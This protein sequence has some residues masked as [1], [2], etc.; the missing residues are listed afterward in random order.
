MQVRRMIPGVVLPA[1]FLC[2]ATWAQAPNM[3]KGELVLFNGK[4][5]TGAG[6]PGDPEPTAIA[7]VGDSIQAIGTDDQILLR[8]G[9]TTQSIDVGGRRIIPGITDSH[10]HL[11]SGGFFLSR[12]QLRDV[13]SKEEFIAAVAEAAK[14]IKPGEWILGGRWTVESWAKPESPHRS[15]IDAAT[16]GAPTM[17]NRMDGHSAL[18]NS[19]ALKLAGIDANG[20]PDP[21]G[22]EIERDPTTKQPTG[23]LKDAAMELVSKHIPQPTLENR[24]EALANAMKHANSLGVT[25]VHD[26]SDPA[27]L[28][29]FL[30]TAE[31]RKLTLRIYSY[32]QNDSWSKYLD[33][34]RTWRDKTAPMKKFRV[35][36]FKGYMDG[37][38]GSRTAYMHDHYADL[39]T[40][41]EHP[42]GLLTAFASDKKFASEISDAD[43][44]GL[45]LA[46]HAI[47][48]EAIS[49]LL[50][51]FQK[52]KED[53][54]R[55]E[56]VFRVEHAQHIRP[57]DI[58]RFASLGVVA[59]MQPLH[60][61]DDGRYVEKVLGR[62]RMKGSYAFGSLLASGATLIFGSDWPVVSLNPFLGIDAAVNAKTLDGKV[63]MPEES[64]SV[65]EAIRAYTT[66]P[67]RVMSMEKMIGTL[68]VQRM[69][70]LVVLS[71][72]PFKIPKE[73]LADV[74]AWKTIVG[75]RVVYSAP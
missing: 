1:L 3:T 31:D 60:K 47:G 22:G 19:A 72:D 2:G 34:G 25:S 42:R 67:S 74:K 56:S 51:A 57:A 20:P 6:K 45:Q 7:M 37:S 61:A 66:T 8:S 43:S 50:D 64:I 14:Q 15:W 44:I 59:S 53:N 35:V 33:D 62:E 16:G 21:V 30:K 4:I 10:T 55:K 9:P 41:A 69:A 71:E 46:V 24:V 36:G 11:I 48:D 29:A 32:V 18:V 63:W 73:K 12:L 27:D 38:M 13:K 54:Q 52:A 5:W 65:E 28:D 40:G 17:L 49:V 58:P 23:I 70:D 75:G 26:M 68:E 39:S